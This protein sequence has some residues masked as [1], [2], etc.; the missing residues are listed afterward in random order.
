VVRYLEPS[1][2]EW[3]FPIREG[4]RLACCDCGL[5]HK[6]DFRVE[7][8]RIEF[9]VWPARRATAQVRRRM[10]VSLRKDTP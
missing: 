8:G 1:P 4:Y 6:F 7:E 3:I 9:R 5:T 10:Q 2:G